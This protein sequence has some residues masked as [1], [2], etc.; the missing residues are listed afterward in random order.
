MEHK[1]NQNPKSAECGSALVALLAL[2]T[3]MA[4][5]LIAAAPSLYQQV[6]REK[7]LESMRRGEEVAEAIKLYMIYSP[8]NQPPKSMDD[9]LKGVQVP[10]RTKRLMILRESA[11]KDPLSSK[12]EW[13]L[14][15]SNDKVLANFQRKLADYTGSQTFTNPEPKQVFDKFAAQI[16]SMNVETT[17]DT[18]PP[19]GE[20][21]ADNVEAPFIAVRSRSQRKSVITFYGIERHD[22]WVF[23]PLFRGTNQQGGIQQ[24]RQGQQEQVQ[25]TR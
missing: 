4:M 25:D 6:L 18:D 20:D 22:W 1:L 10:G 11:A 16:L 15:Q 7:E 13:F 9:L 5:V 19:G 14:V 8:G 17:E 24:G 21:D 12:G 23:T 2:M 3:I